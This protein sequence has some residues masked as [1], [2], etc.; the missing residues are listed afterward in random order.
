MKAGSSVTVADL[1]T[2]CAKY[3]TLA[4]AVG[5][6]GD[7][8]WSF[9]KCA[10]IAL[11][12]EHH[13]RICASS[14]G[15]VLPQSCHLLPQGEEAWSWNTDITQVIEAQGF[16]RVIRGNKMLSKRL[17]NTLVYRPTLWGSEWLP[18]YVESI[19][20]DSSF[21]GSYLVA[22]FGTYLGRYTDCVVVIS[23][24]WP[25][26]TCLGVATGCRV[27]WCERGDVIEHLQ[28]GRIAVT[29]RTAWHRWMV[30]V[31]QWFVIEVG[32]NP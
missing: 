10:F 5:A 22:I 30:L 18:R 12:S 24:G 25:K 29:R 3:T 1:Q 4:A 14:S 11:P 8:V 6:T 26:T 28:R 9:F 21:W 31:C 2:L 23:N 27:S 32:M 7:E 19:L 20:Y 16:M 13:W 15:F 17:P